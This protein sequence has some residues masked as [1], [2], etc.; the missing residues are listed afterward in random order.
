MGKSTNYTWWIFTCRVKLPKGMLNCWSVIS[1]AGANF[2]TLNWRAWRDCTTVRSHTWG[3]NP[4][5][6]LYIA[7]TSIWY[8][9][10]QFMFPKWP[11]TLLRVQILILLAASA[12]RC[13][14]R[15]RSSVS[16]ACHLGR[17][18]DLWMDAWYILKCTKMIRQVYIYNAHQRLLKHIYIYCF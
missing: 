10:L 4:F 9:Y 13:C 8:R 1:F 6:S 16:G 17:R 11:L 18:L 2:R 15:T 7:R 14:A 3:T 5:A 12:G